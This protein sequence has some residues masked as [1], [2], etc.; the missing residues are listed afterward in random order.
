MLVS[1]DVLFWLGVVEGKPSPFLPDGHGG[2][3]N[4]MSFLASPVRPRIEAGSLRTTGLRKMHLILRFF[5]IVRDVKPDEAQ[6]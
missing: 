4:A 5:C 1:M 6:A 2:R 3:E